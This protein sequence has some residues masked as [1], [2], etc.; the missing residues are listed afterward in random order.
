MPRVTAVV[1]AGGL[2]RRMG[3]DKAFVELQGAPLVTLVIDRVR[4]VSN[5]IIV[6][7]NDQEESYSRLGTRVIGDL[8]PGKGSL[9]GIYSGLVAARESLVLAVACDMPFLN[10]DLLRYM[11]SLA[12][13]FDVVVP[14]VSDP[15]GRAP[16]HAFEDGPS[17]DRGARKTGRSTAKESNL[18]PLHAVYS[19]ACLAPMEERIQ[20]DDL[21]M[22]SFFESVRVRVV[23]SP[24][25]DRFDPKHLSFFNANTP[26]D[27]ETACELVQR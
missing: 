23:E 10:A 19:K 25:V 5:E 8:I 16:G 20:A 14:R 13:D 21:R 1:L 15:S 26:Q 12:P 24:E 6:V 9:G 7:A 27:L 2:S 3:R 17:R 11:V 4:A 22:I 18:H